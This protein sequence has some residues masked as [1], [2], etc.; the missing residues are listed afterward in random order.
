MVDIEKL[1]KQ[2][3]SRQE[4]VGFSPASTKRGEHER[5]S[6]RRPRRGSEGEQSSSSQSS[7][8]ERSRSHAAPSQ[9]REKIDPWFLKPYESSQVAKA[10]PETSTNAAAKPAKQ[11]IAAL[12]GGRSKP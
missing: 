9:K 1:I 7:S 3:I 6:E 8:P 12:L 4:L 10:E 2:K 5:G 11:K